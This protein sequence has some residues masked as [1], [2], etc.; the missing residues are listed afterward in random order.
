MFMNIPLARNPSAMR[1]EHQLAEI[2]SDFSDDSDCEKP[3]KKADG[4]TVSKKKA[5]K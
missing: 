2:P 1:W 3:T 4:K 5:A